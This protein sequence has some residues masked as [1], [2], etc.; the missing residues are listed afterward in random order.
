MVFSEVEGMTELNDGKPRVV[1]NVKVM[2]EGAGLVMVCFTRIL[3][4]CCCRVCSM[5]GTQLRD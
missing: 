3:P 5:P 2:A 1:R 4:A